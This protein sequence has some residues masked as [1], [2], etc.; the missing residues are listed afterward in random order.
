MKKLLFLLLLIAALGA[1]AYYYFV[2]A[3]PSRV[4]CA[5][6]FELCGGDAQQISQ[7]Q[8]KVEQIGAEIDQET[9]RKFAECVENSQSCAEVIGCGAAVGAKAIG[10]F[11][12][13]FWRGLERG[14]QK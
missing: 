4:A 5:R 6:I 2:L 3:S 11:G 7:C 1:G 8:G 10:S 13:D 12:K 9:E 14:L